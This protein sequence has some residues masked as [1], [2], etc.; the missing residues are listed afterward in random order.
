MTLVLKDFIL[1]TQCKIVNVLP[2]RSVDCRMFWLCFLQE[3]AGS[4]RI[5]NSANVAGLTFFIVLA[6]ENKS[7]KVTAKCTIIQ[8]KRMQRWLKCKNS[9]VPLAYVK[10]VL[11]FCFN[12]VLII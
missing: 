4:T 10:D 6:S 12:L 8:L 1:R 7:T 3:N 2:H 5:T 11:T 9:V